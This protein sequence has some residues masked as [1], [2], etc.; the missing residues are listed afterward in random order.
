MF[1]VL[2][3]YF[4]DNIVSFQ[5]YRSRPLKAPEYEDSEKVYDDLDEFHYNRLENSVIMIGIAA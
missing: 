5:E 3:W 2:Q 1:Q 4:Y